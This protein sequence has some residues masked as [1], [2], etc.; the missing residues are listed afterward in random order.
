MVLLEGRMRARWP[1][2]NGDGLADLA[3][4]SCLTDGG[5]DFAIV[6]LLSRCQL[7]GCM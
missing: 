3:F 4:G 5:R 2:F 6:V 1:G 7:A